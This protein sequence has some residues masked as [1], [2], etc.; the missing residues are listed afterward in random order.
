[1]SWPSLSL[2]MHIYWHPLHMT[3]YPS[4]PL[5]LPLLWIVP[6]YNPSHKQLWKKL[7]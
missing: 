7:S 6:L 2:D 5:L 3:Y 1:M 4:L